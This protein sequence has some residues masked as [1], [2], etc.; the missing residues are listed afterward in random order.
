[1]SSFFFL[2]RLSL[3]LPHESMEW[4][5]RNH[6]FQITSLILSITG[7]CDVISRVVEH[8]NRPNVQLARYIT[9]AVH[10]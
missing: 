2:A 5:L 1:M 8:P 9:Q 4:H 3:G 10:H 7:C 6:K